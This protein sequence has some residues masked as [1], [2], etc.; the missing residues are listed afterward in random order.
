MC[1]Q[2]QGTNQ[3][4]PNDKDLWKFFFLLVEESKEKYPPAICKDCGKSIKRY[5]NSDKEMLLHLELNHKNRWDEYLEGDFEHTVLLNAEEE[6]ENEEA[7]DEDVL[8]EGAIDGMNENMDGSLYVRF[9]SGQL[10]PVDFKVGSE[11]DA[12]DLTEEEK[13]EMLHLL[14]K[15]VPIHLAIAISRIIVNYQLRE[16]LT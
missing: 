10:P 2:R 3:P 12:V 1:L 7:E 5:R 16:V 15:G 9:F 14:N 4:K 13:S 6:E 11:E 8:H